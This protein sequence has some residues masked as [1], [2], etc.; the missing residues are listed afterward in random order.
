LELVK[1]SRAISLGASTL[2]IIAIIIIVGF[3]AFLGTTFP[4]TIGTT[5]SEM[6]SPIITNS[7]T[8]IQTSLA[9]SSLKTTE[10][11]LSSLSGLR[12]D[13]LV[14][15]SNG[16][17]GSLVINVDEYNTLGVTNNASLA[18]DWLYPPTSL[19]PYD[20]C[21]APGPVGFAIFQGNYGLD[22]YTTAKALTLYNSTFAF[23]CTTTY[24]G[25]YEYSFSPE[26]NL[27]FFANSGK[28]LYNFSALLSFTAKGYWTGGFGTG[29]GAT[30]HNF[31]AGTYTVLAADEWGKVVLVQIVV[32]T[33]GFIGT[34]TF[35]TGYLTQNSSE[36]AC[37][38][39]YYQV[40]GRVSI[41]VHDGTTYTSNMTTFTTSTMTTF[42]TTTTESQTVGY[43][44]AT[45]SYNPPSSWTVVSCTYVK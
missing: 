17:L 1:A 32:S 2:I 7:S 29:L 27:V 10:S 24:Q 16:S 6:S 5:P 30:F 35:T 23:T 13:L 31:P 3:G 37:V 41:S 34:S 40:L 15:P 4:S 9:T 33:A 44:T 11:S 20:N 18:N 14:A 26:S 19:N 36:L 38:S 45:T 12:L 39:T 43:V 42:T 22:N 28:T 21:G 25:N 8:P